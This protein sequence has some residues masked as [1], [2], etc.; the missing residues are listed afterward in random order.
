MLRIHHWDETSYAAFYHAEAKLEE[1]ERADGFMEVVDE[2][3]RQR[4]LK[5]IADGLPVM[6]R[7]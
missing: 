6:N 5:K 1:I 7:G 4:L 2:E 3:K